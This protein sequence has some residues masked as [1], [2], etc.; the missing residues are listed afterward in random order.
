MAQCYARVLGVATDAFP[1]QRCQCAY[2][3]RRREG[4]LLRAT[5]LNFKSQVL[6]RTHPLLRGFG[7]AAREQQDAVRK[8]V[9]INRS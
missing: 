5:A 2:C 8:G 1:D 9:G 6:A 4:R 3:G 7:A